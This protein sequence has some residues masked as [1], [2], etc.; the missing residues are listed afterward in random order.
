MVAKDGV[1]LPPPAFS[2]ATEIVNDGKPDLWHTVIEDETL[3]IHLNKAGNFIDARDG[4]QGGLDSGV[5]TEIRIETVQ[6]CAAD[7][8][9]LRLRISRSTSTCNCR[10]HDP[11]F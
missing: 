7:F 1:K 8:A 9:S 10:C 11:F 5:P 3:P 4:D 6:D 2:G